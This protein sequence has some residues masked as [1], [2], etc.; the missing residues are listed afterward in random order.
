MEEGDEEED[1][2]EE[3]QEGE[4]EYEEDDDEDVDL[5]ADLC[6]TTDPLPFRG[7]EKWQ[8]DPADEKDTTYK[9][10]TGHKKAY[11]KKVNTT[12]SYGSFE[13]FDNNDSCFHQWR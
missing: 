11:E 12:A 3:G 7:S 13:I 5:D 8:G 1:K 4:Q 9:K 10:K 6:D 2:D